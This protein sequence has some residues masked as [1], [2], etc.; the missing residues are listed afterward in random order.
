MSW[1]LLLGSVPVLSILKYFKIVWMPKRRLLKIRVFSEVIAVWQMGRLQPKELQMRERYRGNELCHVMHAGDKKNGLKEM[2]LRA[3][4]LQIA[5]Y[6][7][8]KYKRMLFLSPSWG[9]WVPNHFNQPAKEYKQCKQAHQSKRNLLG[10][11]LW[12]CYNQLPSALNHCVTRRA[13]TQ[14]KNCL[15]LESESI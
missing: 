14:E 12:I 8:L 9:I 4:L 1:F 6:K 5:P 2:C 3:S 10:F 11:L 7:A 15:F 13:Y